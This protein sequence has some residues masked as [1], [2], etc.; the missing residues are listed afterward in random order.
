MATAINPS[1]CLRNCRCP[2]SSL[3]SFLHSQRPTTSQITA[4]VFNPFFFPCVCRYLIL[5]LVVA[6]F[7]K[8]PSPLSIPLLTRA[9]LLS[10]S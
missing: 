2:L 7:C 5:S 6:S 3:V 4:T 10:S 9:L 8:S 1:F